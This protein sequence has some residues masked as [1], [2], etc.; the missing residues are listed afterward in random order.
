MFWATAATTNGTSLFLVLPRLCG[1]ALKRG[2]AE[3][4]NLDPK[5]N[6]SCFQN[7]TLFRFAPSLYHFVNCPITNNLRLARQ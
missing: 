4:G 1:L 7:V 5:P 6:R 3:C 2:F